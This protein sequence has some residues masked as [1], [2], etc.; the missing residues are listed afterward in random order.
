MT[1][2]VAM[3]FIS[4]V[5]EHMKEHAE[6][7]MLWPKRELFGMGES[8]GKYQGLQ[9]ALDIMDNILNDKLE[10]EKYS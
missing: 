9:T 10:K 7:T 2:S 5:R 4:E 3:K 8:V 1:H 6:N